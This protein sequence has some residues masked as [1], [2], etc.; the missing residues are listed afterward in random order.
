MELDFAVQSITSTEMFPHQPLRF[1][2]AGDKHLAIIDP[3]LQASGTVDLGVKHVVFEDNVIA[4]IRGLPNTIIVLGS[5]HLYSVD[6]TTHEVLSSTALTS[7]VSDFQGLDF[8]FEAKLICVPLKKNV[9]LL[10]MEWVSAAPKVWEPHTSPATFVKFFQIRRFSEE[11]SDDILILTAAQNNSELRFWKF[12]KAKRFLLMEEV[13]ISLPDQAEKMSF[14]ISVTSSEEYITLCSTSSPI[15]VVI[16]VDSSKFKVGK[17]TTWK[18]PDPCK[19]CCSQVIPI[20]TH[21]SLQIQLLVTVR[22]EGGFYQLAIDESKINST[23]VDSHGGSSDRFSHNKHPI[24]LSNQQSMTSV[25]SSLKGNCTALNTAAENNAAL[26]V[27]HQ[28]GIIN[29]ELEK[30]A[31]DLGTIQVAAGENMR[32]LE[33]KGFEQLAIKLGKEFAQRNKGRLPINAASKESVVVA[34]S[35]DRVGLLSA[36]QTELL[37]S[38]SEYAAALRSIAEKGSKLLLSARLEKMLTS[39]LEKATESA[40]NFDATGSSQLYFSE[41]SLMTSVQTDINALCGEIRSSIRAIHANNINAGGAPK[42]LSVTAD[43]YI[44]KCLSAA[45]KIHS[46]IDET[47]TLVTQ[48]GVSQHQPLDYSAILSKCISIGESGDWAGALR[49]ALHASDVTLLLNFLESEPCRLNMATLTRPSGIELA[50]FLSLCLQL[51][52]ELQQAPGAAPARLEYLHLFLV[53]WDS[54]LQDTK[55]RSTTDERCL[56]MHSLIATELRRVLAAIEVVDQ[57]ELPRAS[58]IKYKVTCKIITQLI[59]P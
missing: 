29:R 17:I 33:T 22:T 32:L 52:Y 2:G 51:S 31:E 35:D 41:S 14:N 19:S 46:E 36:S 56:S 43:Q 18:M 58:R 30:V 15:A 13:N 7:K 27:K 44:A 42:A 10:D 26:F 55:K 9:Q 11:S 40:V 54:W 37:S 57:K 34:E 12:S 23:S 28:A 50:D 6:E 3:H 25:S 8:H 5:N 39:A 1:F 45:Q 47:K 24:A 49:A 53:E 21:K 59:S 38:I 20:A 16:E 48:V 4:A